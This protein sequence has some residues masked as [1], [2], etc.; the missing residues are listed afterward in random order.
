MTDMNSG[1]ELD[2]RVAVDVTEQVEFGWNDEEVLPMKKCICGAVWPV[3]GGPILGIEKDYPTKCPS[4]GR[5][6]YWKTAIR[7]FLVDK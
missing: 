2:A 1:R 7:V 4:C 6:Y 5:K 3:W